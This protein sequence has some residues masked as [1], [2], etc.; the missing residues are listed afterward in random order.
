MRDTKLTLKTLMS[1]L[2]LPCRHVRIDHQRSIWCVI[3]KRVFR[4]PGWHAFS[5]AVDTEA[6]IMSFIWVYYKAKG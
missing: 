1:H 4:H 2:L 5:I 6:E 3:L